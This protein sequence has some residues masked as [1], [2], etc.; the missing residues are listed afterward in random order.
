MGCLC[1]LDIASN[2][3]EDCRLVVNHEPVEWASA[4]LCIGSDFFTTKLTKST[5]AQAQL[6]LL[7]HLRARVSA[8][9]LQTYVF[10]SC[11]WC[12]SWSTI[13]FSFL[14]YR[15]DIAL[16]VERDHVVSEGRAN[17]VDSADW[18][19]FL[20]CLAGRIRQAPSLP[21]IRSKTKN[22]QVCK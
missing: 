2:L 9:E 22:W 1:R 15:R 3:A 4:F 20:E 14:L 13:Q 5:K 21:L 6:K 18:I 10:C 8:V 19:W 11:F 12:L 7:R 16:N 17:G